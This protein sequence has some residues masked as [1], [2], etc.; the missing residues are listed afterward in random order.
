MILNDNQVMELSDDKEY[1]QRTC[2]TCLS[3]CLLKCSNIDVTPKDEFATLEAALKY[4]RD[5]YTIGH[6]VHVSNKY[7]VY[8]DIYT[9]FVPPIYHIN[10]MDMIRI[11]YIPLLAKD[12]EDYVKV[13]T[14]IIKNGLVIVKIDGHTLFGKFHYPYYVVVLSGDAT[15]SN[16]LTYI[17][18]WNGTRGDMYLDKLIDSVENLKGLGFPVQFI[19][20]RNN[21]GDSNR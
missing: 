2:Q 21:F 8:I 17:N 16:K 14:K 6:L 1:T 19:Q 9:S 4:T 10:K 12:T 5:D 11:N 13:L 18:F 7:D 20:V 3:C 15:P